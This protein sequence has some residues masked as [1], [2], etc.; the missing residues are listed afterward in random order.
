MSTPA[1]KRPVSVLVVVHCAGRILL[2]ERRSPRGFWQSVTGSLEDN[3]SPDAAAI[4]ELDEETGLSA[5]GLADLGLVQRFPILPE[6]SRRFEPGVREN[7]EHAFALELA[8]PVEPLLRREE[9]L[10][11]R[12]LPARDALALASSWTNRNAIRTIYDIDGLESG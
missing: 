1:F 2:L 5:D 3:E 9:H 8:D 10:A 7:V 12:W 6:W 4:R 11:F